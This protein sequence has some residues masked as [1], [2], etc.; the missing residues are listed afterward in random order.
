MAICHDVGI[1]V[2]LEGVETEEEYQIV[3]KMQLD[4]IQGYLFGKPVE[5]EALTA[6]LAEDVSKNISEKGIPTV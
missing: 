4:D 6:R 2:C 3:K 1:E 5:E